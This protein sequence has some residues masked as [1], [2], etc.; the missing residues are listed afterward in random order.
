[1]KRPPTK[2]TRPYTLLPYSTRFRAHGG[3]MLLP[4]GHCGL[5]LEGCEVGPET[6]LGPLHDAYRTIAQPLRDVEDLL[7][8][9]PLVGA[10]PAQIDMM[11]EQEIGR[12]HV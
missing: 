1:M 5:V 3:D 4:A 11:T 8:L 10:I 9:G 7:R 2:S 6:V 12:A